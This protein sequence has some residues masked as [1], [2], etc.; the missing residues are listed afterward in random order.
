MCPDRMVWALSAVCVDLGSA[1]A[2]VCLISLVRSVLLVLDH[3]KH[4]VFFPCWL[5]CIS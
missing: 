3:G 5:N 1:V 4:M 2:G